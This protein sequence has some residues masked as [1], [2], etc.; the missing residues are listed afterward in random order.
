MRFSISVPLV[1]VSL[2]ALRVSSQSNLTY[3]DLVT[4]HERFW[5][6]FIYPI[7][8]EQLIAINLSL[9]AENIVGRV[10]DSDIYLG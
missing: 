9:Y 8:T 10:S 4:L 2:L 1:W 6:A 7:S 3:D 5:D